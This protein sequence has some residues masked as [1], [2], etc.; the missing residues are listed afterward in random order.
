[1]GVPHLTALVEDVENLDLVERGRELRFH[2]GAGSAGANANF[3]SIEKNGGPGR[4]AMRTYERGVEGDTL[5]C[6][7]GAVASAVALARFH[8][9]N[10]PMEIRSRGGR[11]LGITARIDGEF[12]RDVWLSGEG[13]LV[14]EGEIQ[15]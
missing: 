13:R 1:V 4:W 7:T 8:N 12:A 2:P 11:L 3:V 15:P 14:F 10:L 9:V 6:G 5:A